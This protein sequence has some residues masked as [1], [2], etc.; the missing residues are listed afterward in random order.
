MTHLNG[1]SVSLH[2]LIY[3]HAVMLLPSKK[4]CNKP[5]RYCTVPLV[6]QMLILS[7]A[8]SSSSVCMAYYHWRWR[9]TVV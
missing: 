7:H 2:L 3:V 8:I 6:A 4:G 9:S 5:V 1:E